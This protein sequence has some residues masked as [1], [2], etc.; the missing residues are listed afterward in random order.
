MIAALSHRGLDGVPVEPCIVSPPQS[1][2]RAKLSALR[3]KDRMVFG[4]HGRGSDKIVDLSECPVMS[5]AL[6]DAVAPLRKSLSAMGLGKADVALLDTE[7]GIDVA[8]ETQAEANL[9]RREVLA[10]LAESQDFARVTWARPSAPGQAAERDLI[11]MRR[12][13]VLRFA[14]VAV[15]PPPDAFV[16]ATKPAEDV[17]TSFVS[18]VLDGAS[19]VAD[20]FA[21]CGTFTFPLAHKAR[22]TSVD[23]AGDLVAAAREGANRATGLK[24][25][26]FETRDLFRRPYMAA[27]LKS[28]DGLV[29]DPPRQGA[30]A[31]V[32]AVAASRIPVVAAVSCDPG[33]FARDA[34][35][36]V[37]GGYK[38]TRVQPIDQFLWSPHVELVAEFRRLAESGSLP[39]K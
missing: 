1:R 11:V 26:T 31:Q 4:F 21:G 5:P 25:I 34:R 2:R 36:L 12:A 16:Q 9:K 33:T 13:P 39:L 18:G 32:E 10:E 6:V 19:R 35:I 7:T 22:V 23:G 14:G 15:T 29:F 30:K 28:F 37:D 38:L 20:L 24:G 3:V 27:E 8:I 17:M